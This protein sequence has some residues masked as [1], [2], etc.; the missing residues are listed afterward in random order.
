[1]LAAAAAALAAAGCGETRGDAPRTTPVPVGTAPAIDPR[2]VASTAVSLVE[3]RLDVTQPRVPRAGRIA[4]EVTN[5]GVQR[6][7]LALDGPSGL[8]RTR[9]LVP[10]ERA[11]LSATLPPG[12][13]RWYCPLSDHERRGMVGRL[14]VAE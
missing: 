11:I 13:Y 3:Y 7:A 10:G 6:H 14:R 5:D 12:T 2:T 4:I 9:T 8:V 1:M